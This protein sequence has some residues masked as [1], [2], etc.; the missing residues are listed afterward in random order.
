[1]FTEHVPSPDVSAFEAFLGAKV[2]SPRVL[3]AQTDRRAYFSCAH[4]CGNLFLDPNTG[5]RLKNSGGART[6]H[7]LFAEELVRIAQSRLPLLTV[8]FD[9]SLGR[10]SEQ[11]DL[12]AKFRHLRLQQFNGFAY[13]SHACFIVAGRDHS[14]VDCARRHIVKESKLPESRFF[15]IAST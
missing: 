1:M 10:G 11:I 15:P 8:V 14:L 4:S 7:Y 12:D 5:L 13:R 9:Q 2:I 3:T 6:R